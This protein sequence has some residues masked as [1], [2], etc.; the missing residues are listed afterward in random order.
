[1]KLPSNRVL[2]LAATTALSLSGA[3]VTFAGTVSNDVAAE[4]KMM[5]TNGDGKISADEHAAGARKMFDRMDADKDSTVTAAEMDKASAEKG[6]SGQ[7]ISSSEK[8]RTIDTNGDGKL[9]AEEHVAGSHAMFGKMDTDH[10]SFV[11]ATELQAGHDAML[12]KHK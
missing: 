2:T 9:S 11:T 3:G 7:Q 1:M 4:V 6:N 8:I 12:S 5:D 10:D